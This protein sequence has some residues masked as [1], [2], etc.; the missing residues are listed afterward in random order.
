MPYPHKVSSPLLFVLFLLLLAGACADVSTSD[1]VA[2]LEGKYRT[3]TTGEGSTEEIDKVRK[4][5][6]AAYLAYVDAHPGDTTG[7]CVQYLDRAATLHW[8]EPSESRKAVEIYDRLIREYPS[9]SLAADALFM[10]GFVLSN[11]LQAYDEARSIYQEFL[12]RYPDHGLAGNALDELKI[13]GIPLEKVFESWENDS[14]SR[15]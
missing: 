1:P 2:E 14:L 10:K 6:I 12:E 8:A 7:Q 11:N 13:M 5:L 15:D 3:L 9:S 4:E